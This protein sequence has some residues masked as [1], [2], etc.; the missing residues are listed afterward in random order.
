MIKNSFIFLPG[1]GNEREKKLWNDGVLDWDDFLNASEIKRI[2]PSKKIFY[3][4]KIHEAKKH[5]H[6]YNSSYFTGLLRPI[7]NWRLYDFFKEDAVFLDIETDGLNHWNDI[8]VVGLYDGFETKTMIK[9]INL[10]FKALKEE[11]ARYK[12]IITFN[13]ATFDLPFIKKRYPGVLPHIPHFDLRFACR[14]IGLTGGLKKIE[15]EL[16]MK[17]RELVRGLDGGDALTLWKM[18]KGSGDEHY[19]NLLVEYN[20]EDIINLKKIANI[21]T[22]RLKE[23]IHKDNILNN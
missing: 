7:E 23:L 16:G 1:I 10:N 3:N 5:L 12:M 15:E 8:T 2:N 11:L 14:R 13:G 9:D 19:L 22:R 4:Q 20:E 17:R 6:G 21:T 18:Y